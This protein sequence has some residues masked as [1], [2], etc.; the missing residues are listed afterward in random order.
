MAINPRDVS[1]SDRAKTMTALMAIK[2]TINLALDEVKENE[3]GSPW[4]NHETLTTDDY[5]QVINQMSAQAYA[6]L[7]PEQFK[8]PKGEPKA[9]DATSVPTREVHDKRRGFNPYPVK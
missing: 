1:Y 2:A 3:Y 7:R 4:N 8:A 9:E 6:L 5:L